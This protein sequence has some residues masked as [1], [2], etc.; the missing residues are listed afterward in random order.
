MGLKVNNSF[1]FGDASSGGGGGIIPPTNS[2]GLFAQTSD[3][4]VYE[5]STRPTNLIGS[6]VGTLSVPADGFKVADSFNFKMGGKISVQNNNTLRVQIVSNG[7][8]IL[9]DSGFV[10]LGGATNKDWLIDTT[11]TIREIGIAG[12]ASIHTN[13]LF[14]TQRNGGQQFEGFNSD[15]SNSTTFDTKIVNTLTVVFTWGTQSINNS[16]YS[17]MFVLTKIF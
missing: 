13:G 7:S 12:V 11:F 2:F 14:T 16:M 1:G 5:D 3:G 6:G 10:A 8:I 9:A 4:S 17:D 15:S